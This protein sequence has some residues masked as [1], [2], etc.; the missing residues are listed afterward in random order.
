MIYLASVAVIRRLYLNKIVDV[1]ILKRLNKKNAETMGCIPVDFIHYW[2][3]GDKEQMLRIF[4]TSGLFRPNKS[5]DYYEGTAIKALRE[6]PVKSTYTPTIP[7][8]NG[9]NGKR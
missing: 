8:N 6:I 1:E 4:A 3:N 5:P 2:C 7:K 9:G